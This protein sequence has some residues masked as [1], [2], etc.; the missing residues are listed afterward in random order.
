MDYE[1]LDTLPFALDGESGEVSPAMAASPNTQSVCGALHQRR[2]VDE[3]DVAV[4]TS[5]VW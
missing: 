4:G 3:G 1:E 2:S 5:R